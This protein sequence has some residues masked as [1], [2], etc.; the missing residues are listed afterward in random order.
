MPVVS[1]AVMPATPESAS[2]CARRS[3]SAW[4]ISP[5][6]GQPKAVDSETLHGKPSLPASRSTSCRPAS[7]CCQGLG[8][9]GAGDQLAQLQYPDAGKN[10]LVHVHSRC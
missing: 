1:Q 7:D 5:S 10:L 2:A 8:C 3:T 4:A 6:N 9:E